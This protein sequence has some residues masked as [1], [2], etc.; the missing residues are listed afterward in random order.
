MQKLMK[1]KTDSKLK[2]KKSI[3]SLAIIILL[4]FSYSFGCLV[5]KGV[6]RFEQGIPKIIHQE[7]PEFLTV[8][9]E[10]FWEVWR[11][12]EENFP[13][14][15]NYQ[16]LLEGAI[17]GLVKGLGDPY[18]SY[19]P[20]SEKEKFFA[21]IEGTFSGIGAEIGL[22]NEKLIIIS[23]LKNTPASRAGLRS[24]DVILKI[25]DEDTPSMSL[26]EAVSKIRGEEGTE[27]SLTILREGKKEPLEFKITRRL[28]HI[29]S[30]SWERKESFAYIK[31]N[32]F[33]EKTKEEFD[34]I[35]PEILNFKPL[36]IL[37]LKFAFNVC[38]GCS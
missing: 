15:L 29:E 16:K 21:D 13:G 32:R 34:K 6:L 2:Y 37:K 36:V 17:S 27:V 4:L 3:L 38:T 24:Q 23:V 12:I 31:I 28:I 19:I 14:Q 9:F 18:S 20:A 10:P 25:N 33:S 11:K 8:D 35:A 30:I 22:K 1:N 7:K 5:G 26:D